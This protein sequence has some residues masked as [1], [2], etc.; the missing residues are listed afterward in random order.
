MSGIRVV[1]IM[2]FSSQPSTRCFYLAWRYEASNLGG[3]GERVKQEAA[4]VIGFMA[5]GTFL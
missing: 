2:T 5:T 3:G 1:F 4:Y